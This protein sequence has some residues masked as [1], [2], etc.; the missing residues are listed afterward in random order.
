MSHSD[1]SAHLPKS[2]TKT[3]TIVN[4]RKRIS[5]KY[6]DD[7]ELIEE[8]DVVTDELLL[9]KSRRKPLLGGE[10]PWTIEVGT[11]AKVA[12]VDRDLIVESNTAPQLTRQDTNEE[13]VFRIRN[14][15]Y[16]KDVFSVQVEA[17]G[18]DASIGAI[19]VR[20]SNKKYFKVIDITDLN[21]AGIKLDASNVSWEHKMNTLVIK[22]KKPL[23]LR[24]VEMQEKKER[25]AMPAVRVKDQEPRCDQQ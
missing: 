4:G 7:S 11:E 21:R 6:S 13:Y 22:Y 23:S 10:G 12:N 17:K 14:L 25:A 24:M 9:R 16:D 3:S 20:T 5:T 18:A 19:V 15:P 2:S 1:P 8:Y